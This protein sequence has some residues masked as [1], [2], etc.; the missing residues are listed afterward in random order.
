VKRKFFLKGL[1]PLSVNSTYVRGHNGVTKSS[2]AREWTQL[3]CHALS[4]AE[5]VQKFQEL[6]DFLDPKKHLVRV[7]VWAVY[8]ESELM[9]KQGTVS[10]KTQDVSNFEKSIIDVCFLPKFFVEAPPY[11]CPNL[12]FDDRVA[13]ELHSYKA[14]SSNGVRGLIVELEIAPLS[15]LLTI[16]FPTP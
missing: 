11:G 10:A 13:T 4:S 15:D 3:A 12:N 6:R 7:S 1:S 9:T 5:N 2:E 14:K 8:P 16:D